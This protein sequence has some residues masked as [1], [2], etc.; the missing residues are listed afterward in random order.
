MWYME[1]THPKSKGVYCGFVNFR[2]PLTKQGFWPTVENVSIR[3]DPLTIYTNWLNRIIC[4]NMKINLILYEVNT[5]WNKYLTILKSLSFADTESY[6]TIR[7]WVCV[8]ALDFC[9]FCLIFTILCNYDA[10]F[11]HGN[12]SEKIPLGQE[13]HSECIYKDS[14]RTDYFFI[15]FFT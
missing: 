6:T 10:A 1:N 3:Q 13:H 5:K 12:K 14:L 9:V 8:L 7:V 11:R 2:G 4:I 15:I